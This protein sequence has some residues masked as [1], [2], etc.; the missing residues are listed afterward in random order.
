MIFVAQRLAKP[1]GLLMIYLQAQVQVQVNGQIKMTHK[2][3]PKICK[4]LQK[5]AK[6]H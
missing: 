3:I 5:Y 1:L 6:V 4:S 2:M